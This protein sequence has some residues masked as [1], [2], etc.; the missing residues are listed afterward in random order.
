[1]TEQVSTS[2]RNFSRLVLAASVIACLF[3][4]LSRIIDVYSVAFIGAI[5]EMCGLPMLAILVIVPF[6][7]IFRLSKTGFSFRSLYLYSLVISLA[8]LAMMFIF[9]SR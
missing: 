3:W 4:A 1:M 2:Q 5:F 6:Y 7:S 8:G 9:F